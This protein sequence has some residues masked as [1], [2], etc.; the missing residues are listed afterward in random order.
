MCSCMSGIISNTLR[1]G[2][3]VGSRRRVKSGLQVGGWLCND[4]SGQS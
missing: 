4:S 2:G 1:W 3:D